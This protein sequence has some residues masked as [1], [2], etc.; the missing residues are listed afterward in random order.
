MRGDVKT[1]PRFVGGRPGE[2]EAQEGIEWAARLNPVRFTTNPDTAQSPEGDGR[3]LGVG[4]NI[5]RVTFRTTRGLGHIE[6]WAGGVRG[7]NP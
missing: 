1:F 2:G 6:R 5:D 4:G 3:K 7:T